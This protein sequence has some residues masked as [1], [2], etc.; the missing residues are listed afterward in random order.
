MNYEVN[1]DTL[2]V[3]PEEHNQS[4]VLE[5]EDEYVVDGS[6]YQVM[7]HSCS[8]FGSSID[9]RIKGS[10][11]L[12]GSVYRTPIVIEESKNLIFFPTISPNEKANIWISLKNLKCYERFSKNK[13]KVYFKN[14]KSIIVDVPYASFNNQVLRS[15]RLYSLL[16]ERKNMKKNG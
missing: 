9:G 1:H 15:S 2:V 5:L 16:N 10:K 8:Y 4:V 7:E 11:S 12:I 3:M 14:N 13:T 6:P